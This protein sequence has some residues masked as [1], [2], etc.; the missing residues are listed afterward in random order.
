MRYAAE[1]Y[2]GEKY[3][4]T[5]SASY[6]EFCNSAEARELLN[7]ILNQGQ[8][9]IC[10]DS[11]DAW[12]TCSPLYSDTDKNWCADSIGHS[13]SA[14]DMTCDSSWNGIECP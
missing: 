11:D 1:G 14:P 4:L 12:V 5:G 7:G 9:G 2:A 3:D 8:T 10:N 6:S 13:E